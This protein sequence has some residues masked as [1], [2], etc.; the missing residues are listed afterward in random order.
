MARVLFSASCVFLALKGIAETRKFEG[1]RTKA[2]GTLVA[3]LPA[4]SLWAIFWFWVFHNESQAPKPEFWPWLWGYLSW[5]A[6]LPFRRIL[7]VIS[8]VTFASALVVVFIRERRERCPDRRLHLLAEQDKAVIK[9]LLR[10][11]GIA[12]QPHFDPEGPYIDFVVSVFN[13]SLFDVVVNNELGTSYIFNNTDSKKF[14]YPA[15]IESNEPIRVP[16][17]RDNFFVIRQ[18]LRFEEIPAFENK[19]KVLTFGSLD[20]T[21]SGKEISETRL[22]TNHVVETQKGG[23]RAWDQIGFVCS[24]SDERWAALQAGNV[25]HSIELEELRTKLR[26]KDRVALAPPDIIAHKPYFALIGKETQVGKYVKVGTDLSRYRDIKQAAFLD[27][28]LQPISGTVSSP[29]DISATIT[30]KGEKYDRRINAGVW[31]GRDAAKVP[32]RRNETQTLFIVL[33]DG[34]FLAYEHQYKNRP[35]ETPVDAEI[36]YAH[37][38]MFGEYDQTKTINLN[39]YV[40]LSRDD[41]SLTIQ[42]LNEDSFKAVINSPVDAPDVST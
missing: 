29:V 22:N 12:Y 28:Y 27:V 15:K 33:F 32:L 17:R 20:I 10:I 16:S 34:A 3:L 35:L 13:G 5:V 39:W 42:M 18:P 4:I 36:I 23:W 6:L 14:Y 31:Y 7:I 38:H 8:V 11:P 25:G 19:N 41:D 26:E 24:Y 30:L 21:F 37:I 1:A 40:K 2:I 9:E